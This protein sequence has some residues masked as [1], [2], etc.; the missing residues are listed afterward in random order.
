MKYLEKLLMVK[1][2]FD[3]NVNELFSIMDQIYNLMYEW[4]SHL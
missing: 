4:R 3:Q 2:N 1:V